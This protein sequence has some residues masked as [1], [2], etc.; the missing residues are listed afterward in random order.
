MQKYW[1]IWSKWKK[2]LYLIS[3]FNIGLKFCCFKQTSLYNISPRHIQRLQC[4][5]V[6]WTATLKGAVKSLMSY[7]WEKS[8]SFRQSLWLYHWKRLGSR[9]VEKGKREGKRAVVTMCTF[10]RPHTWPV[11]VYSTHECRVY[12]PQKLLLIWSSKTCLQMLSDNPTSTFLWS[13]QRF[14]ETPN[15]PRLAE[16]GV[17]FQL[18]MYQMWILDLTEAV[19][20]GVM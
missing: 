18:Q 19:L 6:S 2:F 17:V 5:Y 8:A 13:I 11:T 7:R 10:S 12:L 14:L 15:P 20:D 1:C 3:I 4:L 16:D 9:Y